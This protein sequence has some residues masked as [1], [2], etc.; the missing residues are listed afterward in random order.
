MIIGLGT[1]IVSVERVTRIYEDTGDAFAERI[2]SQEELLELKKTKRK[3]EF[4]AK[5]FAAKEAASKALGTGIAKGVS[6][7]DF[8]VSH[9]AHGKPVLL[10][11]GHARLLAE[12]QQINRWHISLSDER[13]H[14]IAT[15]IAEHHHESEDN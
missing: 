14:A 1:D 13:E 4:L 7:Q 2:L 12:E 10:V 6:F 3:N 15:V 11:T 8:T 9:D 5:R